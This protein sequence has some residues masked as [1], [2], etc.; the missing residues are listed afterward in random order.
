MSELSDAISE[1]GRIITVDQLKELYR[2]PSQLVQSKVKAVIDPVSA[3]F[4]EHCPFLLMGTQGADGRLDVSPRGGPPGFIRVLS[5]GR[6]AI[7]D[8]NGNNLIDT[9][10]AVVETGRVGMIFVMPGREETLRVN[11]SAYVSVDPDLLAG[12][13]AELKP[14]KAAIVVAPNEVFIHC[15]KAFRRGHVWDTAMWD[16]LAT[17]APDGIDMLSCHLGLPDGGAEFRKHAEA[18]YEAELA[19]D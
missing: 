6:V 12:F 19:A 17:N 10:R 14:P 8:L 5:D 18:A 16:E 15:A 3:A 7:P 4:I 9:L 13:T 11:G 2:D 1:P